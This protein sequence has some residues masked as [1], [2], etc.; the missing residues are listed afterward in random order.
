MKKFMLSM[1]VLTVIFLLA[2]PDISAQNSTAASKR[3]QAMDNGIRKW[4]SS[5]P[6]PSNVVK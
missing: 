3:Q 2:V 5:K 6:V 4:L 1:S